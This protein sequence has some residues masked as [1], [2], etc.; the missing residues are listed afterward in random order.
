MPNIPPPG[1]NPQGLATF[2]PMTHPSYRAVARR[3]AERHAHEYREGTATRPVGEAVVKAD[4]SPE[5]VEAMGE[6][7][8]AMRP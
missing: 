1:D 6:P 4:G 5:P 3:I 8:L 2:D 7:A